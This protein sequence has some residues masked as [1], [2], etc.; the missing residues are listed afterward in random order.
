VALRVMVVDD[1][2]LVR[3]SVQRHFEDLGHTVVLA[4]SGEQCLALFAE[5]RP[6]AV[7]LDVK[8]PGIDGTQV[9]DR[10]RALAPELTVVMISAHATVDVAVGAIKRGAADFIVKP[11][12]LN[13]LADVVERSVSSARLGRELDD[14]SAAT[15]PPGTVQLVGNSGA[16]NELRAVVNKVARSSASTIVIQGESGSGKEV[17]ARSVHA[18]S[19]RAGRPFLAINCTSLPEQLVESELFGHERGAFTDAKTQKK[20]LFE[21]AADGTVLLDEIGDM[22]LGAQAKLLRVLEQRS[23][24]R[25]GGTVDLQL[26]CRIIAATH[27]DLSQLV[28]EG[29]FRQDL[30][31]RL[32]VLSLSVP[33]L[34]DHPE[35]LPE[36]AAHLLTSLCHDLGRRPP[37]LAPAALALM[38][39]YPWPGNVRQLRNALERALVLEAQDTIDV[40]HLPA[41]LRDY[42]APSPAAAATH[43]PPMALGAAE[44]RLIKSA[45]ERA[46]GNQVRAAKLLGISRDTLRY[47]MK[48]FGLA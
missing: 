2:P 46:T 48:K 25:V 22:P 20:G 9:L 31:F 17:V 24:K 36:I 33:P 6:D 13:L 45:L 37:V 38:R 14:L 27:R 7:L 44:V 30:Y 34:R 41:A 5:A 12:D 8:L 11:F 4:E 47:R 16:M 32:D 10:L 29:S 39:R 42:R 21:L 28:T 19:K 26:E 23:F 15:P 18:A 35:D 40:E 43:G 3:W 1:E